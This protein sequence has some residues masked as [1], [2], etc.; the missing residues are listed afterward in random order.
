MSCAG[1]CVQPV[2][3]DVRYVLCVVKWPCFADLTQLRHKN[4]V[5]RTVKSVVRATLDDGKNVCDMRL[6]VAGEVTSCV[7]SAA[8]HNKIRVH[9]L[10]AHSDFDRH[11]GTASNPMVQQLEPRPTSFLIP[12][13]VCRLTARR[14]WSRLLLCWV[15]GSPSFSTNDFEHHLFVRARGDDVLT[16][17]TNANAK[18]VF[19]VDGADVRA[20][21]H[22]DHHQVFLFRRISSN[23]TLCAHFSLSHLACWLVLLRPVSCGKYANSTKDDSCW[24]SKTCSGHLDWFH[25]AR[26][27]N[28]MF[29]LL[30]VVV[31][32]PNQFFVKW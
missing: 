1:P 14:T 10:R 29:P 24:H 22:I 20:L 21:L 26:I 7:R 3:T 12:I 11:N 8:Q 9:E 30:L 25:D 16:L 6:G 31:I 23:L 15:C 27:R 17:I 4:D 19:E 5:A 13:T 32:C 28:W 18:L 2:G